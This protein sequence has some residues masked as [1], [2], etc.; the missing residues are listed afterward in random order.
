MSTAPMVQTTKIR[1]HKNGYYDVFVRCCYCDKIHG[2]GAGAEAGAIPPDAWPHDIMG[3]RLSHCK[4]MLQ[5]GQYAIS[6]HS[7]IAHGRKVT[8]LKKQA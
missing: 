8:T 4:D 7:W 1:K 2:H 6:L 5:T 3:Q